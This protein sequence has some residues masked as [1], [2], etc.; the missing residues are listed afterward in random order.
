MIGLMVLISLTLTLTH[1]PLFWR[2]LVNVAIGFALVV[3]AQ[4]YVRALSQPV[5]T[6]V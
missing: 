4:A 3:S 2:G 1:T 5:E 6:S